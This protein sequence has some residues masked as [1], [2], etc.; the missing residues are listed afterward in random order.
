MHGNQEKKTKNQRNFLN[1][2]LFVKSNFD[3]YT[4]LD[5]VLQ[6]EKGMD[7]IRIESWGESIIDIDILFIDDLIIDTGVENFKVFCST[8]SGASNYS[9]ILLFF[10]L[11]L[12]LFRKT[13]A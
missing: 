12:S 11:F 5:L 6:I 3:P 1:Q 10:P 13:E 7:R 8:V 9:F 2:A 4:I